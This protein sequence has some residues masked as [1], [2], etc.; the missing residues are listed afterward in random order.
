MLSAEQVVH[1]LDR[2]FA[3][4]GPSG[5]FLPDRVLPQRLPPP[6]DRHSDAAAELA[7]HLP[8]ERGG[9]RPWLD[10]RFARPDRGLVDAVDDLDELHRHKLLS[11]LVALAHAYRW[12]M[13]PPRPEQFT[14]WH[15]AL[16]AGIAEPLHAVAGSLDHPHVGT[17][18]SLHSCNWWMTDRPGGATYS[19]AE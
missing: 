15:I 4:L 3:L 2:L 13:V 8:S 16:P 9:V 1:R 5:A 19:A 14:E 11:T 17:T 6:F 12:H 10:G 7:E 18:W